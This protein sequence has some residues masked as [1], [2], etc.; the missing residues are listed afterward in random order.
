MPPNITAP[1]IQLYHAL[2]STTKHQKSTG[3]DIL[4]WMCRPPSLRTPSCC[5]SSLPHAGSRRVRGR[6]KN[7]KR[8]CC[9]V[10]GILGRGQVEG[11]GVNY[12]YSTYDN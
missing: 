5:L 7:G 12:E 1:M 4:L 2:L 6:K 11:W 9:L 10:N 3:I 8:E